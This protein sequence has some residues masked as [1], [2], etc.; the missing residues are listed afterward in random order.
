[1]MMNFCW[2]KTQSLSIIFFVICFTFP[3]Y[4]IDLLK[5]VIE[6]GTIG[7]YQTHDKQK[8]RYGHWHPK[9]KAQNK[10]ILIL[11]GRASFIE[12][13]AELIR[14][15]TVRGYEIF[16]FDFTGQGLSTRPIKHHHKGHIDTYDTYI[17]NIHE[18][19]GEVIRKQSSAPIILFGS[20]MG[21]H[22]AL[23]YMAEYPS[24][25]EAA[26]LESPMLDIPT[27][28]LPKWVA[29]FMSHIATW[30]NLGTLYAPGYGD[31]T[32][33]D[34]IFNGNKS[35]HDHQ[36]FLRQRQY[37][38]EYPNCVVGGPTVGWVKATFDSIAILHNPQTLQKITK[39]VL[40]LNS[41]KD[42]QVLNHKDDMICTLL[43][44]CKL[45]TFKDAFHHIVV[46]TNPIRK[47]FWTHFDQFLEK[48]PLKFAQKGS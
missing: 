16:T 22:I 29:N 30:L 47:K 1:M 2:N 34:Y 23:R 9:A 10:I 3:L 7:F 40:L 36:R 14:D 45:I 15:L 37:T 48:L 17:M 41:S 6:S 8:L 42:R 20:S 33:K 44:K 27:S 4:S 12:K 46:E 31:Y 24:E 28:P 43:P 32:P 26:I 25:I 18:I 21:G 11:Q 13:H 5:P 39:P 19:I 38:I 35:T